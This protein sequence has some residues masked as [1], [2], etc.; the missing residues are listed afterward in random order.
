LLAP[1]TLS[2]AVG[3]I[4]LPWR[5][6]GGLARWFGII[7]LSLAAL[8]IY[9]LV[10]YTVSQ[11]TR[12]LGVRIALGAEPRDIRGLVVGQGLKLALVGVAIGVAISFAAARTL[13]AFLFGVSAADPVTYV[14]TSLLLVV[15]A[16]AASYV[17]ARKATKTDPLV[18]LRYE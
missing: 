13:A 2:A 7:G 8:G 9:G 12:E 15:V 3:I 16:M 6:A 14:S 11:R 4:T 17:P 18:A 10:V 5:V 1:V